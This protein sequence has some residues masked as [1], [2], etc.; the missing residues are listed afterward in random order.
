MVAM[1]G[2]GR[3]GLNCLLLRYSRNL[4]KS[5]HY[6]SCQI[7]MDKRLWASP[8]ML[9][10]WR[11][12]RSETFGISY[13]YCCGPCWGW[14]KPVSCFLVS[15][16]WPRVSKK[17]LRSDDN[18][19]ARCGRVFFSWRNKYFVC[20]SR[21]CFCPYSNNKKQK[22]PVV[23]L[24]TLSGQGSI[25]CGV[26]LFKCCR[27]IFVMLEFLYKTA[28]CKMVRFVMDFT[29]NFKKMYMMAC[30]THHP[31]RKLLDG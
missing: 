4:Y 10:L 3:G 11:R 30:Q 26:L 16:S 31:P 8:G 9:V 23:A 17:P 24:L 15:A 5:L 27:A 19:A 7:V 13:K 28:N 18:V 29:F 21:F 1:G 22:T 14:G 25:P 6:P 20:S 12:R 2:G